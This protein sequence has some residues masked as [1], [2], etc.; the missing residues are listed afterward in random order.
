V[1]LKKFGG[2]WFKQNPNFKVAFMGNNKVNRSIERKEDLQS[3]K[4]ISQES[5]EKVE[6]SAQG[7]MY[8]VLVGKPM[9]PIAFEQGTRNQV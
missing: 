8:K 6:E 1:N 5:F 9:T 7:D 4:S 3:P 2:T